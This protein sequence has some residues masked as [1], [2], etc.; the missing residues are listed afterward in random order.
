MREVEALLQPYFESKVISSTLTIVA[1]GLQRPAPVNAGLLIV[2]LAS[3]DE[4]N[5]RQQDLQQELLAKV[6]QIP[7]P[8]SSRSI[9][10]HWASAVSSSRFNS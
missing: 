9:R 2:R 8:G 5:I 10:R 3:W 6:Q 7:A 1:P 4:R